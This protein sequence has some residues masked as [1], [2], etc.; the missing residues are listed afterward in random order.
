MLN[1]TDMKP[2]FTL[3][4]PYWTWHNLTLLYQYSTIQN[5]AS[6]RLNNMQLDEDRSGYIK[7][8]HTVC[9]ALN[10]PITNKIRISIPRY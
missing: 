8:P 9:A 10:T 5:S 6:P 1:I 7:E 3:L 2:D 4:Y